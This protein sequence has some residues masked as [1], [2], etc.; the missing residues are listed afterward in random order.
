MFELFGS[1]KTRTFRVTWMLE[2]LGAD[3]AYHPHPPRSEEILRLNPQGKVPL[4]KVGDDVISDSTAILTYLADSSGRLTWP[5]GTLG[6]ARQD[7][8]LNFLLDEFDACLWTAAR[9]SFILPEDR[10][11]PEIKPT[12]RWEFSRSQTEF[13]RRLGDGPFVMGETMTIADIVATH[14]GTWAMNA[15]FD[16]TEPAYASYIER[17]TARPAYVAARSR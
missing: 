16:I 17:M 13:A 11:V 15:K 3:Y 8:M 1:P 7:S 4:L 5:A 9:N 2:E 12:L 6:R 14:C 10:R